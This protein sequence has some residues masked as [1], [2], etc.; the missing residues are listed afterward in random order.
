[1]LEL[2][3]RSI[4]FPSTSGNEG[5]FTRFIEEWARTRRF[6]TDL[7]QAD[8]RELAEFPLSRARHVPLAGRPTL[9]ISLPGTLHDRK[10]TF[11]AHSD[12]VPAPDEHAW[13]FAPWSGA[14]SNGRIFGRGACDVKGPLVSALWAMLALKQSNAKLSCDVL[15]ELVPGE[16]DCVGLGTL[17]SIARG[18]RADAAIILEPT[19][20]RPC[21]ASRA[22]C[23][24]EIICP[25]RAIH[26]T[27][28]WLGKDAIQVARNVLDLLEQLEQEWNDRNAD[29]LFS[30]FPIA[31]PITVDVV[32]GG[33]GQGMLCD[34][35]ICAGYL[36][37]L[38]GDDVEQWKRKFADAIRTRI[39]PDVSVNFTEQYA[40]HRTD[41]R[42]AMCKIASDVCGGLRRWSAFNSGCEAGMRASVDRTPTLVW[43]PGN[44]AHAHARDESIGVAEVEEAAEMFRR[45]TLKWSERRQ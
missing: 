30:E 38:P 15:L 36:E 21:C 7:W 14:E 35:C 26:G 29:P 34:Q 28:K 6:V 12:V 24:F 2:L 39:D 20:N 42:D 4:Q 27:V 32:R 45:F 25:G 10:L 44:L 33:A 18:H 8:E 43:G 5:E 22:G 9:V 31:R 23:R 13:Q 3:R 37:L 16:E 17:T 19:E 11:N 40:G 1:M 41:E